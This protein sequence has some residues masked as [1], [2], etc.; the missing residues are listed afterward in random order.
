MSARFAA[1]FLMVY[2]DSRSNKVLKI[3]AIGYKNVDQAQGVDM[4]FSGLF[5]ALPNLDRSH[6]PRAP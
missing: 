1:Y 2:L 6:V 4:Q 5:K 3:V